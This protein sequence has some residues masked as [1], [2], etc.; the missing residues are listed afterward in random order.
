MDKSHEDGQDVE[1]TKEGVGDDEAENED[2]QV[3]KEVETLRRTRSRTSHRLSNCVTQMLR[4]ASS[5][6]NRCK[7]AQRW[8]TNGY[9]P[10]SY[11]SNGYFSHG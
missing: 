9:V 1:V 5:S 6:N 4:N 2:A 10:N 3:D 8:F 7:M 11:I